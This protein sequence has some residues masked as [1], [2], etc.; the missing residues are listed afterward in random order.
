MEEFKV[1][2][3]NNS[4]KNFKLDYFSK[5][6]FYDKEDFKNEE[7]GEF[8]LEKINQC[9][10]F[11][12]KGY[13]YKYSKFNNVVKGETKKDVDIQID[14]SLDTVV[15]DSNSSGIA[16]AYVEINGGNTIIRSNA[17]EDDDSKH[18][19]ISTNEFTFGEYVRSCL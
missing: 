2:I 18:R 6:Y 9:N 14:E 10:R 7:D 19:A 11:D 15:I 16:S 4:I 8:I 1:N 12:Y 5:Y 13:T 3:D 17:V